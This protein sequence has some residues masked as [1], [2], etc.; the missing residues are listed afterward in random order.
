[1]LANF[2][3]LISQNHRIR[4]DPRLRLQR[5]ISPGP[6]QIG[7]LRPN[8]PG[9]AHSLL[10]QWDRS[11]VLI[12]AVTFSWANP[13]PQIPPAL[14]LPVCKSTC[15]SSSLITYK[16]TPLCQLSLKFSLQKGQC[17]K[18]GVSSNQD[19]STKRVPTRKDTGING[20]KLGLFQTNR[21]VQ[22]LAWKD[23]EAES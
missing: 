12:A 19:L 9:K 4:R 2:R 8:L 6:F 5:P 11:L 1:M 13:L 10:R 14:S 3:D 21:E 15:P 16:Q 18:L 17:F 22:P 7:K 20:L 23:D